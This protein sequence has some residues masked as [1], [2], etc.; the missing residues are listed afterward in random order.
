MPLWRILDG[1]QMIAGAANVAECAH[2][3]A[4]IG[5]QSLFERGV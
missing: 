2:S 1:D 5:E 4:G 3:F